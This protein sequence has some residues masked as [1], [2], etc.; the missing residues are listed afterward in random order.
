MIV[1]PD[2]PE[3]WK[4]RRLVEITGD[5]SAPMAVIRLWAHCQHNRRWNFPD[6]TPAQLASICYW[7]NRK[8]ACHVAL[9]KTRFVDRLKPKGFAARQWNEHN[10]QLIQRWHA[11]EKGGRPPADENANKDE[12]NG[13]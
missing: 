5:E 9:T 4:T 13:K 11:G 12:Q 6:M 3:H 10:K 7:G 2:F 8:P 1:Q